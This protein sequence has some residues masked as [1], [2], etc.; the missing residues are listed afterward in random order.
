MIEF[1]KDV[2]DRGYVVS[3]RKEILQYD[4]SVFSKKTKSIIGQVLPEDHFTEGKVKAVI[5]YCIDKLK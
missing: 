1:L 4:I 3:F 2:V 5:E